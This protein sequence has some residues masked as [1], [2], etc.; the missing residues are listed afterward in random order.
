M[1]AKGF[2]LALLVAAGAVLACLSLLGRSIGLEDTVR[3]ENYLTLLNDNDTYGCKNSIRVHPDV[4]VV[5]DSHAYA[6]FDFN[7]LA[8]GLGTRRIATCTLGGSYTESLLFA[9]RHYEALGALP[10]T[11]IYSASPRQF[12]EDENKER[13]LFSHKVQIR[14]INEGDLLFSVQNIAAYLWGKDGHDYERAQE[15]LKKHTP[16]VEGMDETVIERVLKR[17]ESTCETLIRWKRSL[18]NVRFT[19]DSEALVREIG[20]VVRRNGVELFVVAVPESRWLEQ[21][22]PAWIRE[23][24]RSLL[25][26]F[27]PYAKAVMIYTAQGAG[28]GN[29]H[30]VNGSLRPDYA[31]DKWLE[32][33]F[34][35]NA[36]DGMDGDHMGDVRGG[37]GFLDRSLRWSPTTR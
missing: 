26:D 33:D 35:L 34:L 36:G 23:K 17:S 16:L 7:L 28:L 5:G 15:R 14:A 11:V 9:L 8:K 31:Y 1:T 3:P 6:A 21:Q 12:W 27:S 13:M 25:N 32:P 37:S 20:E 19:A 24:Y 4:L 10:K 29:R 22:Y 2:V 18:D 30:F